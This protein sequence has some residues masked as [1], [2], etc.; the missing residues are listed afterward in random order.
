MPN[1]KFRSEQNADYD[2]KAGASAVIDMPSAGVGLAATAAAAAEHNGRPHDVQGSSSG[3]SG[4]TLAM[5]ACDIPSNLQDDFNWDTVSEESGE[6]DE[7]DE[8]AKKVKGFWRMHP[9]VRALCIM[10]SGGLFL[11]IPVVAVMASHRDLPFRDTLQKSVPNYQFKYNLQCVARSF[12]LLAAV[13]VFGTLIYHLV[14]MVPDAALNIVR[15]FKGKRGLEKLKD[16]MQFFIAVKAFI[17]MILISATSLIAFVIMFPN[18]SY[19][20]IGKVDAGS[21]SWDQALFQINVLLLFACTI[22]GVEKLVL[23]IIATR[24]HKSAYK[25]RIEQQAYAS[26]VLDHLN[27]SREAGGKPTVG[28]A[29]NTPYAMSQAGTFPHDA[30]ATGSHSELLAGTTVPNNAGFAEALAGNDGVPQKLESPPA[31]GK[32]HSGSSSLWR[33]TFSGTRSPKLQQPPRHQ[34]KPSKSFATRLWNI[35]DRALDGGI[36]MNSNQ[37]ASRLARKLF[38]AL[39][40]DRD[41]LV[42]D[43]F[44]P[45]FEK[46]EDAIKAFE[47]FD[48]DGNGDISKREMRDRVVLIY[49]ERRSLISALNDMSQVVGKLDLFMTIFALVIVL[50][51]AL[52]VFGV[53]AL[54]TFATIGPLLIGWSFIFGGA[55]K[56]AFECLIFLFSVHSYDVGDT[57]VV[58]GESLT[59]SKIWLLSTVFFKTDGTYTVYANSQLATM[60]IQNLR[61]SKPQSESIIIGLDFNTPSDKIYAIRERMNEYAEENPRDLVSP[62]G[63][64]VDLL[65]NTNR[66]Q[67]SVGIN[68][69]S[70][71][72]DGAKHFAVK[73]KFAFALR[74]VIHELGLRYALPLQ[75]VTMVSPPPGYDEDPIAPKPSSLRRRPTNSAAEDSD[76]EDIFGIRQPSAAEDNNDQQR[77]NAQNPGAGRQG[78]QN[79]PSIMGVAA[80]AGMAMANNNGA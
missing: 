59:V 24:F 71:W 36:D 10:I 25:E 35:K 58:V 14:D 7:N 41:Y 54:K 50:I 1:I 70:N 63:F 75:P 18:A 66:V 6:V 37:Y 42:V 68:Y 31:L 32:S 26:W 19:R 78:T 15:T 23:K 22:I 3:F 11:M 20:F 56:T 64:N 2:E 8:G 5:P 72:Q 4:S 40:S 38:G 17:K 67:I 65:E 46:E 73:T 51:V 62:V 9:L 30:D 29:G 28:S 60:K 33:N 76:D 49:K 39:H 16:R 80:I 55:C 53:D 48:K 79:D 74:H 69:K 12:A 47:F 21:S 45:F 52:M 43:D 27:R 44:L 13:W 57:V 61:R 34:K 77:A